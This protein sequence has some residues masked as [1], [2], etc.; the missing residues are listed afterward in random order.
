MSR[1]EAWLEVV[2]PGLLTTVQDTRGRPDLAR[3]GV[4]AAG[5]MD[6]FAAAAA[7]ALV[8]NEPDAA[9]LEITVIG[10]TLRFTM[11]VALALAG[12]DLSATVDGQ[13]VSP[14]WSWLA[15]AGST[16]SFGDR[17]SGARAYLACAGGLDVPAV[18]GS[19][20]A[21]VRA[22]FSGFAG[23][24]VRGGDRLPLRPALD[25][26]SRCGRYLAAAAATGDSRQTVRVLPGPHVGRFQPDAL[27]YLCEAEWTITD[28]ADRMGYRLAG[29]RLRH[30]GPADVASLG[31]PLGS[32]Q[33]P[34][35]GQPIVLLADHQ[36]TGGYTVPACV[37][38]ADVPLLAQRVPGDIV[39]FAWTTPAEAQAALRA[40]YAALQPLEH[41]TTT[42]AG[43]RW[44]ESGGQAVGSRY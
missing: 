15:R 43:L 1:E 44:A 11:Q 36:P 37:I 33:V 12:A 13:S 16:L 19:R 14:G 21:D 7:N 17:C 23:R 31:L 22:G 25:V 6:P 5:A 34:G 32:V 20:A 24:A 35:N 40:R 9:L 18:L 4:P 42:W 3:Y 39:R 27:A 28:Q 2:A 30:V 26:V 38:R 29:P 8:G 41:D 10:P